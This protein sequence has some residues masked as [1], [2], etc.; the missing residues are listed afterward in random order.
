MYLPGVVRIDLIRLSFYDNW[1]PP[2][3]NFASSRVN[4]EIV[5]QQMSELLA[6]CVDN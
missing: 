2:F 6:I 5:G 1:L 3:G 4:V